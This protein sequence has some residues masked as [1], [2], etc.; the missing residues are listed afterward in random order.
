MLSSEYKK[1]VKMSQLS[2]F[3]LAEI[4][5]VKSPPTPTCY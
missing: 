2:G 5:M 4:I 3:V 1:V